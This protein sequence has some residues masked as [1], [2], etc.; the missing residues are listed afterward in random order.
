VWFL[1]IKCGGTERWRRSMLRLRVRDISGSNA[2]AVKAFFAHA[3]TEALQIYRR[4]WLVAGTVVHLWRGLSRLWPKS[5][6][7]A[8]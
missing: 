2:V 6:I 3:F 7:P 4:A 1:A 5:A 8:G